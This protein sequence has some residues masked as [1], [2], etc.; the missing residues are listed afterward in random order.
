MVSKK[1]KVY[2]HHSYLSM[3]FYLM[4]KTRINMC[5]LY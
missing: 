5:Y 2:Q 3:V 1:K 4:S